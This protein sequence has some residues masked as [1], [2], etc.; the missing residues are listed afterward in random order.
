MEKRL[1]RQLD[2][3][4]YP[5]RVL[6]DIDYPEWHTHR[7]LPDAMSGESLVLM[8]DLLLAYLADG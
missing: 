5:A 4:G 2:E 8:E 3:R 7:D 1:L 6:I